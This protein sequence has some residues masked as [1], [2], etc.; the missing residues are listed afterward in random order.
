[1]TLGTATVNRPVTSRGSLGL[2]SEAR[3]PTFTVREEAGLASGERN[4]DLDP[5]GT[6]T[7]DFN[8]GCSPGDFKL[9]DFSLGSRALRSADPGPNLVGDMMLSLESSGRLCLSELVVWAGA[10]TAIMSGR[11]SRGEI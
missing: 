7:G 3:L 2:Q 4:V 8:G 6:V 5:P 1:M 11:G 10:W 9:G